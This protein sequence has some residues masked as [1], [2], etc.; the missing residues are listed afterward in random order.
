MDGWGNNNND[1][2]RNK[3]SNRMPGREEAI[4][5]DIRRIVTKG[6]D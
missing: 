3:P 2:E 5:A 1:K 4:K 6:R